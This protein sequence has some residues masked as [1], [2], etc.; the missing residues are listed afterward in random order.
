MV[1]S[2][3]W[4]RFRPDDARIA[5]V[6]G[7]WAVAVG[8]VCGVLGL[9]VVT[10]CPTIY[11]EDAA[12]FS[13]VGWVMGVAHPPGYPLYVM[14]LAGFMRLVRV[15]EVAYRSNL[16]SAVCGALTTGGMWLFLRR[17]SVGWPA[18]LAA[19]LCLALGGTFWSL[20]L[21][22]EV[23]TFNCLLLTFSLLAALAAAQ[24]PSRRTFAAFGLAAGLLMG[25]RNLNALFVVPL[26]VLLQS[27]RRRRGERATP[28]LYALGALVLTGIVYLYLPLAAR[29]APVMNAGAPSTVRQFY[30]VVTAAPYF[31]H[32]ASGPVSADL[33]R[34][35]HFIWRLP[36]ELGIAALAA[37]FG[38]VAWYRR[39]GRGPVL[40]IGSLTAACV[41]FAAL[42][43]VMDVDVY[44]LPAVLGLTVL[45]ALGMDLVGRPLALALPLGA[46]VLLPL[47]FPSVNLHAVRAAER[48]GMDLLRAAPP[49]A[50]MVT[51]GDTVRNV[52]H[53][54]QAVRGER[55]DLVLVG[56]DQLTDAYLEG[57]RA[58]FPSVR[59]GAQP[60]DRLAWLSA[61]VNDNAPRLPVC[62]TLPLNLGLRDWTAQP[63][64]LLSCFE[65]RQESPRGTLAP[66][67]A[68]WETVAVPR[69]AELASGEVHLHMI[70]LAYASARFALAEALAQSG[71]LEGAREQLRALLSTDPERSELVV[72][73]AKATIGQ[74][75]SRPIAY[76]RR[77]RRA[78]EVSGSD[79]PA[80]LAA[81]AQ[82]PS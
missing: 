79:G 22:A 80:F 53:Y 1:P 19:C 65:R 29:R 26:A 33:Q 74:A 64:G 46:L 82:D 70:A 11:V 32:F 51:F 9:F 78:L 61:L 57:L 27:G 25:H 12:E 31:R 69:P 73:E 36:A 37:P 54:H 23:H 7:D 10:L 42:Y 14:L 8:L 81:L 45:A 72:A 24:A 3:R 52:V 75:L 21:T 34:I 30:E 4:A 15:G 66:W 40:A 55:S 50:V 58:R 28:W 68:F 59:W 62:L 76:G 63:R 5:L 13:T 38:A 41:T 60:A 77:A 39:G 44:F 48:Y 49:N 67:Q 43:N 47:H 16:F 35:G 56:G 6:G 71:D 18:A 17:L 20:S 2:H